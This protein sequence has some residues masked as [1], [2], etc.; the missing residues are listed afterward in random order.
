MCTYLSSKPDTCFSHSLVYE[1]I[2]NKTCG[3]LTG[4]YESLRNKRKIDGSI[5]IFTKQAEI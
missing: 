1:I 2:Y 5:R 3:K 4:V